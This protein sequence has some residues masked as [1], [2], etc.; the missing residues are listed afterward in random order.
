MKYL[1]PI[2]GMLLL[3]ACSS[4]P[5]TSA[6]SVTNQNTQFNQQLKVNNPDLAKK[7]VITDVKT[8]QTNQLTDVVVT[9]SSQYKKSQK[10]QYQFNWYD[11]DGFIIKGEHSPWQA[12]TLFGFSNTQIPG[13]APNPQATTFSLSVRKVSTKPQT[14]TN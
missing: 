5:D 3:S 11:S 4:Q 9:L 7:I 1:I 13:L 8:R 12:I 10:L 6:I 2:V 14:F